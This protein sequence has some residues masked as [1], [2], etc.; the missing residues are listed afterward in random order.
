[1]TRARK[2]GGTALL[3]VDYINPLDFGGGDSLAPFALH[4]ARRTAALKRRAKAERLPVIYANDNFGRWRSEFSKLVRDCETSSAKGRE[5]VELL[6]P[7]ADDLSILKPRHSAFYGTPLEFLLDELRITRLVLTGLA[8]DICILF[9]AHDA[10]L[11]KYDLWIPADCVASEKDGL[12]KEALRHMHSIL[13]AS[14]AQ[15][16][17]WRAHLVPDSDNPKVRTR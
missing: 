5:L 9:T 3:L 7:Q 4:A 2:R 11:R 12:R 17:A 6:R 10:Y 14:V 15:S 8:A 1:M 13:R 16:T